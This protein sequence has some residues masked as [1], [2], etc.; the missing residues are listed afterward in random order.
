[1]PYREKTAWLYLTAMAVTYGPYFVI[2]ALHPPGDALPN[3]RQLQ[4][5]ALTAVTHA[6][7][8][9][10]GQSVIFLQ[11][12]EEARLPLDERDRAIHHR[13]RTYGYYTLLA[14]MILVGCFMPIQHRGWTIVNGALFMIVV[15][16]SVQNGMV[17]GSYRRQ[18]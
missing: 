10:I 3:L 7:L 13:S 6:L 5:F 9:A 11:N 8:V 12:R 15:A 14:G 18:A 16:E 1:M 4:L 17:A 2:T